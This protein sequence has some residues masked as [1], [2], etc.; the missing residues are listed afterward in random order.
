MSKAFTNEDAPAEATLVR[1]PPQLAPGERRYITPEGYRA[2]QAEHARLAR[3][4][5]G[6]PR[7]QWLQVTL[8]LLTVFPPVRGDGRAVFGAWVTVEEETRAR[9]TYRLV[10]PDEADVKTGLLS[11]TSPLA[12]AL[13]GK[14][15][16]DTVVVA[17]PRGSRELTIVSIRYDA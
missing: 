15:E 10:G 12:R 16:G 5:P 8:P 9:K 3:E 1:E 2:L 7:V 4:Q 6:N 14:E 17:S 11:M 13:L